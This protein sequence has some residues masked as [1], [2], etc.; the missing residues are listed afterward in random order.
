MRA[1]TMEVDIGSKKLPNPVGVASGTFGYGSEY[2]ELID[3]SSIGALYAKSVTVEP[4]PGNDI[5]RLIETH[6]GLL[7]SIGLANVGLDRYIEE[8]IPT[9]G[10]LPC[11]VVSNIAGG[12]PAEYQTL[13][14]TLTEY[15]EL[16]GFEVNLSCPN[17]EHGLAFGT[18][19]NQVE[20]LISR[21]RKKTKKP[22]IVKLT[23]NV[24][25][26]TEIA[27]AVE[28][29]GAD[30]V[31][32]INTLVGMRIDVD[33]KKTVLPSGTGGL[34]G[35][36]I[37]P[38]GIAAVYKVSRAVSIPV[39]GVGG[40]FD[41]DDAVEY[42]LAGASAIQV[43]TANFVDPSTVTRVAEGIETFAEKENLTCIGDFHRFLE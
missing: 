26:I 39:I 38:V 10:R 2:E 27:K 16:W 21:I 37:L 28:S 24:T 12:T 34:S 32:C 22:L 11:P 20:D 4:R 25:E 30:A 18:D 41:P 36:A 5:P 15:D 14:E 17:V 23:P 42:L 9:F 3:L 19:P 35:P 29:A 8:K 31:T 13:A 33:R 7:N 6:S 40:I 1:G 43:G